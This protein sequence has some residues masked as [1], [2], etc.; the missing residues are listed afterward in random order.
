MDRH[1]LRAA[2]VEA[3]GD[4]ARAVDALLALDPEAAT[5]YLQMAAATRRHALEPKARCLIE[6]AV[7][8]SPVHLIEP[9]I[10]A[11]TARALRLGASKEELLDVLRLASVVGVHSLVPAIDLYVTEQGG[12]AALQEGASGAERARAQDVAAAFRQRRGYWPEGWADAALLASDYVDAYGAFS[13]LP[14]QSGQ[15]PAK[16]RELIL[17]A[18]DI[19]PAH[20]YV[21]G[22][23]LHLRQALQ[24]GATREEIIETFSIAALIGF[25]SMVIATPILREELARHE[26]DKEK[27][28]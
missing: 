7:V 9:A 13:S 15:L 1:L 25:N 18:I 16:L 22:A 12:S 14:A 11:A 21:P 17:L 28:R 6:L 20:F 24:Q 8:A 27:H 4:D 2:L 3:L 5:R 23:T 26:K 19:S 10:R